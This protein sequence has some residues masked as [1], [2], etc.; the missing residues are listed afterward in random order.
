MKCIPIYLKNYSDTSFYPIIIYSQLKTISFVY[1][2][3][4]IFQYLNISQSSCF[5]NILFFNC[6]SFNHL[7][8]AIN[9]L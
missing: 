1:N 3:L 5:F 4:Y 8:L 7:N 2:I 9:V 6:F